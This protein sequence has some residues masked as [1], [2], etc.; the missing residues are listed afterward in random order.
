MGFTEVKCSIVTEENIALYWKMTDVLFNLIIQIF[1]LV[2]F[3]D[4]KL[5]IVL[6]FFTQNMF[7]LDL[8]L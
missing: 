1:R 5:I 7:G 4:S 6:D 8:K 2:N 3:Q